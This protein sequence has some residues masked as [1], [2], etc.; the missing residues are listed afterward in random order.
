MEHTA[1]PAP[2]S[3]S[4][5][6]ACL[7]AARN[8]IPLTSFQVWLSSSAFEAVEDG[9]FVVRFPNE[10]VA[11][12]AMSHYGEFLQ[13]S[14]RHLSG[15]P[16]ICLQ[17]VGDPAP[18]VQA[19][20]VQAAQQSPSRSNYLHPNYTF[21]RFVSGPSNELAHA[22][23]RAVAA[24]PGTPSYNPLFIYGGVGLGKTHLVQAIAH[25][26]RLRFPD[27]RYA[28][29][30]SEHF[31]HVYVT[32]VRAGNVDDFRRQ[33]RDVDL[34]LMDDVQFLAG[35]EQTQEEFFHRFNDMYQN[36]RQIVLTSD[37]LPGEIHDLEERLVSRFQSGLVADIQPPDY[38]T[39]LAI[40]EMKV[41]DEGEFFPPDVL[42]FIATTH[43][44]NVRLL[45]G[46]VHRLAASSRI[47]GAHIDLALARRVLTDALA[48]QA[49]KLTPGLI[50]AAVAEV[51]S[52]PPNH[53]R[54]KQRRRDILIPRQVAM[55]LMRELTDASL[56]DIG[57][58]F[59]G[60]DHST[61]LNSIERIK[62]LASDDPSLRRKIQEL[63]A[64]FTN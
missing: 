2:D 62:M 44:N 57:R 3:S 56:V 58:F 5:W 6:K 54:G 46:A 23:A 7:E 51:F 48:N 20:P 14:L 26:F 31:T 37:R 55:L 33:Y 9:R 22:G 53:L 24:N 15:D 29:V 13:D 11:R 61:V 38:E 50:T 1:S 52:V 41:R 45:E 64:R 39:R 25:E 12:W 40:L 36:G 34:L 30:S 42:D 59:S 17:C 16:D 8:S 28:Y 32:A 10:F 47:N 18:P 43:R 21:D 35:K 63:R 27:R 19:D 60:R 49:Q 4:L